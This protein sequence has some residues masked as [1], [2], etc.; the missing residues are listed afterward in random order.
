MFTL[1]RT[2]SH[3]SPTM[4]LYAQRV[5]ANRFSNDGLPYLQRMGIFRVAL[6]GKDKARFAREYGVSRPTIYVKHNQAVPEDKRL[7]ITILV[8]TETDSQLEN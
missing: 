5:A 4:S 6:D 1:S 3:D 8:W 7:K 2:S